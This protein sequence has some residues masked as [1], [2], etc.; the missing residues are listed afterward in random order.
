MEMLKDVTIGDHKYQIGR[1][2]AKVGSWLLSQSAKG[3]KMTEQD[4]ANVQD[5][6]L[7]VCKR[8][9]P[10]SNVPMPVMAG[11]GKFAIAE[12]EYDMATVTKLQGHAMSFNFDDFLAET[13][14]EIKETLAAQ[15]SDNSTI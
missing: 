4:F 12:L 7:A 5:H 3:S 1:F 15:A 11:P 14:R 2:T 6:C 8:Y 10:T 13:A 9:E